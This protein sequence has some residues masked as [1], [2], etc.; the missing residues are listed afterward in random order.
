VYYEAK[1]IKPITPLTKN[2]HM[3]YPDKKTSF[4]FSLAT[5]IAVAAVTAGLVKRHYKLGRE[6]RLSQSIVPDS[7]DS[8]IIADLVAHNA[9]GF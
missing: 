1:E 5:V 6:D 7:E 3:Q 4:I 9:W 2:I 8:S